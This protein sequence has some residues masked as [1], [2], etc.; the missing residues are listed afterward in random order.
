MKTRRLL[1]LLLCWVGLLMGFTAEAAPRTTATPFKFKPLGVANPCFVDSVRFADTYLG[2]RPGTGARWVRVLRWGTLEEDFTA[3]QG[4]AVA[5]FQWRGA[6]F[7]FDINHGV[8]R[9]EVPATQ[10]GDLRAVT[11]AVF[12]MYPKVR[13]VGPVSLDDSWTTRAPGLRGA[14][15]DGPVTPAYRDAYR[16]AI[17]LAREREVRLVRFNY[18]EKGR[19]RESAAAVFLFSRQFCLYVPERGTMVL[20]QMI[21]NIDDD[22]LI[23]ARLLRCFGADSAVQIVPAGPSTKADGKRTP[24]ASQRPEGKPKAKAVPALTPSSS[25]LRV[26]RE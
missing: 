19:Q 26:L 3:A 20:R 6:L 5:V 16:V 24:P 13:P 23:R 12:S 21:P 18:R 25:G 15:D 11:E 1:I 14:G 4:H 8:R 22:G 7:V 10:R 9:L 2:G 17:T